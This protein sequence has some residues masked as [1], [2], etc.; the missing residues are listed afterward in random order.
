MSKELGQYFT[1][2]E[3]LKSTLY[4]FILN[5]PSVIL[6]PSFGRGDLVQEILKYK[7]DIFF[8]LYEID[9]TIEF[10]PC[11]EQ[12][13]KNI[14]FQDFL[15]SEIDNKYKTIIGNPPY[16]KKSSGNLYIDF[17]EKCFNLSDENG[18]LIFIIPSDFFK[19]TSAANLLNEMMSKGTFTHIFHP[20]N[21]KLFE[22]ASI[23]V[24]IFRY[25]LNPLL[26]KMI[27]YNENIMYINNTNGLVT[28]HNSEDKNKVLLSDYFDVYVGIVSGKEEVF[29]N[30]TFGNIDILNS[31]DK[32][33]KYILIENF[34]TEDSKLNEYLLQNKKE[35]MERKI[36]K[37]NEKNWFEF[38]AL[39]NI[40]N[41][42][43]NTGR[44]CIYISTLSRKNNIAF[45]NKVQYF[46]GGLIM[47]LP[48]YD[49]NL[50][51][52][53]LYL[54]SD[55][56]RSNF[57]FSGRFKIGQRHLCNSLINYEIFH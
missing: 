39:R 13:A 4:S 35:L 8:D 20:N 15:T 57:T 3:T 37:F 40:S 22:N 10:L 42:K 7:P 12:I 11:I 52:I 41:V 21:E 28:F 9:D 33:D 34:P 6:E 53:V 49:I 26:D 14:Y 51:K 32:I 19:L 29:K 45:I 27:Y 17:I 18:E 48:K 5:N 24:L 16:V 54:N 50:E 38:G 1:K 31:E 25:Q 2:N 44:D 36:R 30:D 47:L 56:F 23:D 43:E 55:E 46:G